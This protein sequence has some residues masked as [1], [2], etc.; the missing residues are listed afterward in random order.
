[1]LIV[2]LE[3]TVKMTQEEIENF[4]QMVIDLHYI[5]RSIEKNIGSGKLSQDLRDIADRLNS[6]LKKE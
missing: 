2:L 4:E 6:F 1:M 5:A 3:R